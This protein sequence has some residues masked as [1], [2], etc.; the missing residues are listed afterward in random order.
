VLANRSDVL[1]GVK[2]NP[3]VAEEMEQMEKESGFTFQSNFSITEAKRQLEQGVK[4]TP[5]RTQTQF[6]LF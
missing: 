2:H 6:S 3:E 1:N 5:K 4:I